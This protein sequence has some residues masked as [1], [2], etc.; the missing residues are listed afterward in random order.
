MK[1]DILLPK[2]YL[3]LFD[4]YWCT[5]CRAVFQCTAKHI[6]R[7]CTA[8]GIR[9]DHLIRCCVHAVA[10]EFLWRNDTSSSYEVWNQACSTDYSSFN[11]HMVPTNGAI[12]IFGSG[13]GVRTVVLIIKSTYYPHWGSPFRDFII[14]VDFLPKFDPS[15]RPSQRSCEQLSLSLPCRIQ[16]ACVVSHRLDSTWTFIREHRVISPLVPRRVLEYGTRLFR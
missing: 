9:T 1:A 10:V 15:V 11:C 8:T 13:C 4:L 5:N 16:I 2:Y 6:P 7:H 14:K 12:S 3:E